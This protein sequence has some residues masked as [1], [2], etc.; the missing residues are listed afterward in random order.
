MY[1]YESNSTKEYLISIEEYVKIYPESSVS[2]KYKQR[3]NR[4]EN[5]PI[6]SVEKT[7]NKTTEIVDRDPKKV[8]A[9]DNT[10]NTNTEE[11]QK[12]L[13]PPSKN[14]KTTQEALESIRGLVNETNKP[15]TKKQKRCKHKKRVRGNTKKSG[16]TREVCKKC[17]KVFI[18]E[19]Q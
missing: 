11:T 7:Q 8:N 14:I 18:I 3:L 12:S 16:R 4:S 1:D 15:E 13:Q 2:K 9:I 19:S 6:E 17:D 5:K 10:F